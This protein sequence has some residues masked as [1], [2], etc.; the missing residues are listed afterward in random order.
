MEE[1]AYFYTL[2]WSTSYDASGR[3]FCLIW[4]RGGADKVPDNF[5]F[6]CIF[7]E[8]VQYHKMASAGVI[9]LLLLACVAAASAKQ[10]TLVL[11]ENDF[12]KVSHSIFFEDLRQRGHQLTFK[13]ADDSGLTL[14]KYGEFLYENLIIFAPSVEEFGGNVDVQAIT[15]F[16]D[17][18]KGNVL[19]AASSSVGDILRDLGMEMGIEMDEEGT[20]VI[21]HMNYDVKDQGKH[22]LLAVDPQYLIDAE[23]IVGKRPSSPLLYRGVGMVADEQNPLVLALLTGSSSSYSYFPDNPVKD[24]PHAVGRSTLLMAGM[25][26]RNNARVVFC[27][28]VDF[29]SNEFFVS[30]VLKASDPA[31]KEHETSSN[32]AVAKAI[33]QWVFKEKGVLRVVAV[34]HHLAGE[35]DSPEAYTINDEVVY[36]ITL[37]ELNSGKWVPFTP[38]D[39]QME[40]FRLDPFVRTYLTKSSD[41][42]SLYVK[43]TLPDVYGVFQFKVDYVRLG[44]TYLYSDTQVAVR[45]FKHTQYERF[46]LSAFPYYAAAFSMMLGV[47]LFSCVF[48][49]HRE[50]PRTD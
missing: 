50:K 6:C 34:N 46:I 38:S 3:S 33:T 47:V 40:F 8:H 25:Q 43:F 10:R 26:A 13:L 48:L 21:D 24:Y 15:D 45:P 2:P 19:V 17:N 27:G 9:V 31:G 41:G 12:M 44:Y 22:S 11:L 49:N 32:Q 28:S 23:S 4:V 39:V 29:F 20:T 14:S 16:I 7:H 30:S 37:E 36:S 42:K 1:S 35:K 18:G 5:A